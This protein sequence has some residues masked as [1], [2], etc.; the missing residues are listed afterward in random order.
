VF[1]AKCS[2]AVDK[3]V[4]KERYYYCQ[5]LMMKVISYVLN[6]NSAFEP[7]HFSATAVEVKVKILTSVN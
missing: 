6:A 2:F 7:T 3:V 1:I 5:I 4:I